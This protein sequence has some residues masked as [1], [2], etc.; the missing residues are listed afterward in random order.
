M[1][2][3]GILELI[4]EKNYNKLMDIFKIIE[5]ID[6][7]KCNELIITCLEKKF[8]KILDIFLNRTFDKKSNI[9]TDYIIK[10]NSTESI[11]ILIKSCIDTKI[12]NYLLQDAININNMY[13]VE[14]LLGKGFSIE[15][16]YIKYSI[17][18]FDMVK[19][20]NIFNKYYNPNINIYDIIDIYI[21]DLL[22]YINNNNA[23]SDDIIDR[24]KSVIN[25]DGYKI[26]SD[27]ISI[28]LGT[29]KIN[30]V[31]NIILDTTMH[32]NKYIPITKNNIKNFNYLW[33]NGY[34]DKNLREKDINYY[35]NDIININGYAY[36]GPFL[37]RSNHVI[38]DTVFNNCIINNSTNLFKILLMHNKFL[39][40]DYQKILNLTIIFNNKILEKF[41]KDNMNSKND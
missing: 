5:I 27:N 15:S 9:V 19:Y 17:L 12:H 20:Y 22:Y 11:D 35:I 29:F 25:M 24:L 32:I 37:K 39:L 40:N 3:T 10:N 30:I 36:L 14:Y 33:N 23:Y 31:T 21:A 8:F 26:T 4:E 18:D 6:V 7:D 1:D 28:L 13:M 34:I 2:S 16:K 38:P 41:M